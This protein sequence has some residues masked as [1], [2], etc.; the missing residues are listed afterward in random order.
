[1]DMNLMPCHDFKYTMSQQLCHN[2][3]SN[4]YKKF[5]NRDST[6][7]DITTS[8]NMK[9]MWMQRLNNHHALKHVLA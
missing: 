3:N 9:N 6:F 8:E 4:P 2:Y 7:R 1:M 5:K